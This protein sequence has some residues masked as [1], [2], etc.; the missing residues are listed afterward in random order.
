MTDD[1]AALQAKLRDLDA[2]IDRLANKGDF[3][4]LGA[5]LAS[6][7]RYNHSTGKSEDKAEWLAGLHPLV[8]RRDRVTS[9]IQVDIH[10]DVAVAMGD[11]DI[12]WTDGRHAYDRYVRVYRR[13]GSAWQVFF[14]RT[15][16]AHDRAPAAS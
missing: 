7:F 16:P 9:G 12:V 13:A 11:L 3:D 10:G 14:Q 5:L 1:T 4:A 6:D 15:L 2:S 8:G